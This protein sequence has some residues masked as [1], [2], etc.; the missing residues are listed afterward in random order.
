MK[1]EEW[2]IHNKKNTGY[3]PLGIGVIR[4]QLRWDEALRR[5]LSHAS[6]V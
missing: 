1:Y 4:V 6:D 2:V 5:E 3:L